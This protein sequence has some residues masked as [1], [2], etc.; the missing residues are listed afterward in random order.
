MSCQ[1]A[2]SCIVVAGPAGAVR[3]AYRTALCGSEMVEPAPEPAATAENDPAIPFSGSLTPELAADSAWCAEHVSQLRSIGLPAEL[4]QPLAAK[5]RLQ[6][7]DAAASVRPLRPL[8]PPRQPPPPRCMGLA[9]I[10]PSALADHV[11][12]D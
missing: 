1:S 6:Q 5:L 3:T 8:R 9:L 2:V 11:R 10:V 4:A 7:Y 12:L